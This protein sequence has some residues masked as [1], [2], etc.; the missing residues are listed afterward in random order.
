[1]TQQSTNQEDEELCE[2]ERSNMGFGNIVTGLA[3]ASGPKEVEKIRQKAEPQLQAAGVKMVPLS[4]KQVS[5]AAKNKD[6]ADVPNVN[7]LCGKLNKKFTDV[8]STEMA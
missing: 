3:L 7:R 6:L 8:M 1:M 5:E 2:L 4:P